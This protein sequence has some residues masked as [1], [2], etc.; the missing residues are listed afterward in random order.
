MNAA[1]VPATVIN[2]G[3][4]HVVTAEEWCDELGR[5]VGRDVTIVRSDAAPPPGVIDAE[6]LTALGYVPYVDWRDGLRRMVAH[7]HPDELVED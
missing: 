3:D 5:L 2:W 7:L 4:P 6:A 1:S